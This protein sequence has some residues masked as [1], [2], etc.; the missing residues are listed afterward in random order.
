MSH[1]IMPGSVGLA[2]G[3]MLGLAIGAGGIG[4]AVSGILAD[5]YSLTVALATIP[6]LLFAAAGLMLNVR[7]PWKTLGRKTD[8][9]L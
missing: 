2:S 7:Y 4:V 5:R 3:L 1:E 9:G 8:V 6:F